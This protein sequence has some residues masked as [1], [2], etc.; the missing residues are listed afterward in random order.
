MKDSIKSFKKFII[1]KRIWDFNRNIFRKE[2]NLNWMLFINNEF[3]S[4]HLQSN[5]SFIYEEQ[6]CWNFMFFMVPWRLAIK[7]TTT[8][9]IYHFIFICKRISVFT[10]TSGL[11]SH[12]SRF[13]LISVP[14]LL[15]LLLKIGL[16]KNTIRLICF[17]YPAHEFI[18]CFFFCFALSIFFYSLKCGGLFVCFAVRNQ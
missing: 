14:Y 17:L 2:I 6:K 13:T 8:L 12:I 7:I 18:N 4:L 16:E 9:I 10:K 15:I 11:L 1:Q 3:S 5:L